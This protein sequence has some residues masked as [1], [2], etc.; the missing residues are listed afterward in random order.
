MR[1]RPFPLSFLFFALAVPLL[2]CQVD[3]AAGR[4][5]LFGFS[6][7]L[8]E[9]TIGDWSG[10]VQTLGAALGCVGLLFRLFEIRASRPE[11]RA[12]R[13]GLLL[14]S[15]RVALKDPEVA[16][17]GLAAA[18]VILAALTLAL[19]LITASPFAH[20]YWGYAHSALAGLL[21]LAAAYFGG[22]LLTL[23]ACACSIRRLQGRESTLRDGLA[24]ARL[25]AG[26]CAD[27]IYHS[28]A[29]KKTGRDEEFHGMPGIPELLVVPVLLCE[30]KRIPT[31]A[32]RALALAEAH[33]KPGS[34]AWDVLDAAGITTAGSILL[35][36]LAVFLSFLADAWL[37]GALY[38]SGMSVYAALA[39]WAVPGC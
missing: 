18:A 37:G 9:L 20:G 28:F 21:I 32:D 23:A 26:D 12:G 4:V 2:L 22:S 13:W 7:R 27:W 10:N 25:H 15:A 33:F 8:V 6:W 14:C 11:P 24:A 29:R 5:S 30:G 35:A 17:F 31:A 38:P 19:W 36:W 16:A 34:P 1:R 3:E 39:R